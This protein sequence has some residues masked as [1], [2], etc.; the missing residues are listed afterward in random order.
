MIV[1]GRILDY[2]TVARPLSTVYGTIKYGR[3]TVPTKRFIHGYLRQYT[4]SFLAVTATVMI[5]LGLYVFNEQTLCDQSYC[6]LELLFS[7]SALLL[8]LLSL[9]CYVISRI[10]PKQIE[11]IKTN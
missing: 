10:G 6:S 7:L 11:N 9:T 1:N 2:Q 5:D 4:L 3:S 8:L